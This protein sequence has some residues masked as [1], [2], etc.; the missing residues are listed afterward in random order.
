MLAMAA[1]TPAGSGTRAGSNGSPDCRGGRDGVRRRGHEHLDKETNRAT[2]G[3]AA[4]LVA[5]GRTGR[6][7]RAGHAQLLDGR[8]RVRRKR[9]EQASAGARRWLRTKVSRRA[10]RRSLPRP[11]RRPPS[12]S[13]PRRPRRAISSTTTVENRSRATRRSDSLLPPRRCREGPGSRTRRRRR[14][15]SRT[16]PDFRRRSRRRAA[17]ASRRRL[18]PSLSTPSTLG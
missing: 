9:D 3:H 13:P 14:R 16:R 18:P 7:G 8:G 2:F 1:G 15:R 6:L 12:S 10:M 5:R 11:A 4:T 17:T